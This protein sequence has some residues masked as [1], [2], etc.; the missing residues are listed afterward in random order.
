MKDLWREMLGLSRCGEGSEINHDELVRRVDQIMQE[1]DAD[2]NGS[3]SYS[4]ALLT[5][6]S[7]SLLRSVAG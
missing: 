7:G 3:M 2:H 1:L 5:I 6:G 4:G